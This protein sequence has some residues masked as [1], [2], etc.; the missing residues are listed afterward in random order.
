[1]LVRG[2]RGQEMTPGEFR[3]SQNWVSSPDNRPDTARFVPPPV[4]EM[5]PAL[6][7]GKSTST[8]MRRSCLSS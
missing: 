1:M 7:T 4:E 8:T 2:V 3:R 6:G 5:T